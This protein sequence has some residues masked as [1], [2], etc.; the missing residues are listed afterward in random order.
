MNDPALPSPSAT[1]ALLRARRTLK[2]PRFSSH[3]VEPSV[4]HSLVEAATWA[5]T[6]GLNQPWR[7]RI[8]T[9]TGRARL[10]E[11][12]VGLYDRL[13]PPDAR[14]DEKV[15]GLRQN[16]RAAPCALA[17]FA[18]RAQPGKIPFLEDVEAV[19]CA[20][21]N[22]QLA[23]R[24]HGLGSFWSTNTVDYASPPSAL[25]PGVPESWRYLGVVFVGYPREG[26]PASTRRPVEDVAEWVVD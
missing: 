6:H 26:F 23:A 7:F 4:V 20:V 8:Y 17:V 1:L 21:Q 25:F 5:P 16:T 12:L 22:L 19:A 3:P 13:N 9:G 14:R 18:D 15:A 24:A 2:P 10:E 11:A